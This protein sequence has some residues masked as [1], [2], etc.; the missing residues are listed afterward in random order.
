M[1]TKTLFVPSTTYLRPLAHGYSHT[2]KVDCEAFVIEFVRL[3]VMD[4]NANIS[5]TLSIIVDEC[6]FTLHASVG[7][8]NSVA[9][10]KQAASEPIKP[11]F[12]TE[13]ISLTANNK[14]RK[15]LI[16]SIAIELVSEEV[17]MEHKEL[18][19]NAIESMF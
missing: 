15:D 16:D 5:L 17:Y 10:I 2:R 7:G 8:I 11:I 4:C 12:N 9:F 13:G 3:S 6:L 14:Q 1:K 18:I 19:C